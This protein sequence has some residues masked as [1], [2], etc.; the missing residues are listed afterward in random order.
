MS[1]ISTRGISPSKDTMLNETGTRGNA[2]MPAEVAGTVNLMAHPLAGVAAMSA[3]GVGFAS[4][5]IGA[6]FGA[7]SG[8]AAA[9][10]RLFSP[11]FEEYGADAFREPRTPASRAESSIAKLSRNVDATV[12][13]LRP[14]ASAATPVTV[15]KT[16]E[17]TVL[18]RARIEATPVPPAKNALGTA[19][20]SQVK[21]EPKPRSAIAVKAPERKKPTGVALARTT[22]NIRPITKPGQPD[23]LKAIPGLG[24]KVEQV[25]NGLG[26]WTFSQI[27]AWSDAEIAWVDDMLGFNGRIQRDDWLGQAKT[28]AAAKG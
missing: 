24:P 1:T 26:V 9:S 5:V 15:E 3:I 14:P 2:A 20:R 17:T 28:L 19:K 7:L 16:A 10:H 25:L 4:Q 13:Q 22:M 27:A 8:A 6:W 12:V 11:M 23:D 21:D 18:P